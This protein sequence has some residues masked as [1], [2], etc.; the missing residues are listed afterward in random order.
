MNLESDEAEDELCDL[1]DAAISRGR[2]RIE[3]INEYVLGLGSGSVKSLM[4]ARPWRYHERVAGY[5][6][7]F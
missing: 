4:S 3:S 2:H 5:W 7:F 6:E 1:I